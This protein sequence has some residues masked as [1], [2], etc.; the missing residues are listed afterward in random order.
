M[1]DAAVPLVFATRAVVGPGFEA[2]EGRVELTTD[3]ARLADAAVELLERH[4]P[5]LAEGTAPRIVQPP[6]GATYGPQRRPEDGV[7]DWALPARDV[8]NWVRGL[9]RPYPGAFSDAGEERVRV[10]KVE[11]VAASAP[12]AGRCRFDGDDVLVGTGDGAV[13]IADAECVS[14][15]DWRSVLRA[16]GGFGA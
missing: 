12:E 4:L 6:D 8:F 3:R 5:G 13:R 2:L 7:I 14:G 15:A 9:T 10:W 16:A 11:P 1:G